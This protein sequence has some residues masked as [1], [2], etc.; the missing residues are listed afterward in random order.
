M[1]SWFN[2][3]IIALGAMGSGFD[4]RTPPTFLLLFLIKNT[5][6]FVLNTVL[7]S[8]NKKNLFVYQNEHENLEVG[9]MI[10]VIQKIGLKKGGFDERLG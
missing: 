8:I 2:G 4:S 6:I 3:I 1:G 10:N 9:M 7:A 5:N